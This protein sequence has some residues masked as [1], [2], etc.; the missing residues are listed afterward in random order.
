MVVRI[1]GKTSLTTYP[2]TL[3]R[4]GYRLVLGY[5]DERVLLFVPF[6]AIMSERNVAVQVEAASDVC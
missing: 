5:D 4:G 6:V 1:S 2:Y 3:R